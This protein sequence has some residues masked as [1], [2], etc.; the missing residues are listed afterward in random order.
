ML[1]CLLFVIECQLW[2]IN[3]E[4]ILAI[5]DLGK[6]NQLL[7]TSLWNHSPRNQNDSYIYRHFHMEYIEIELTTVLIQGGLIY[8]TAYAQPGAD[9]GID[10]R[11]LMYISSKSS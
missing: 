10:H 6:R 5:Y 11:L 8:I 9:Y 1:Y 7:L 4:N 3:E 2:N